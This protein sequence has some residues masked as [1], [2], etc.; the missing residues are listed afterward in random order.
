MEIQI[1]ETCCNTPA[2]KTAWVK[3]GAFKPLSKQVAGIERRTYRTGVVTS[4]LG[5]VALIDI[6]GFHPTTVQFLDSLAEKG[7]QVSAIDLFLNGPM[8]DEYM[9]D[10]A[11]LDDWIRT[12]AEY[13]NNHIGE[14]VKISAQD[15]TA[16]GCESLF[17]IGHCW[18]VHLAIRA[19]SEAGQ[20]FLGR[21]DW[22]I[23]EQNEAAAQV[24]QKMSEFFST[25]TQKKGTQPICICIFREQ[26]K[27]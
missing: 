15:L 25:L 3:K 21:G 16:D 12:K 7:F 17:I 9:G 26:P 11:K 14:L 8:P 22:I 20:V 19:A 24:L 18:G 4:K 10:M 27:P 23:P 13:T 2:T 5:V 6:H 1:I